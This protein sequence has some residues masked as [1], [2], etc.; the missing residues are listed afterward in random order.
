MRRMV[1]SSAVIVF[2]LVTSVM[3]AG[4]V[5]AQASSTATSNPTQVSASIQGGTGTISP[6]T[7]QVSCTVSMPGPWAAFYDGRHWG[8]PE[9][10]FNGSGLVNLS[11]YGWA[12][13]AQSINASANSGCFYDDEFGQGQRLCFKG[14][15]YKDDLGSWNNRIVSFR[16]N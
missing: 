8:Q 11:D 1:L 14:G 6:L 5:F 12:L 15:F 13:R 16:I 7:D 2:A 4:T 10:C 9:I 3:L